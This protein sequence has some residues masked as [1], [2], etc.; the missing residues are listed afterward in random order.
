MFR[1]QKLNVCILAK[2]IVIYNYKLTKPFP[3]YEKYSSVQQMNKAAISIPSNIAEEAS[4]NGIKDRIH[5]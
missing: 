4:R 5:F 3:E 2:E 1:F